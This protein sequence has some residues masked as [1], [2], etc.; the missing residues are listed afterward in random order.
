MNFLYFLGGALFLT[1]NYF[2][3]LLKEK[4]ERLYPEFIHGLHVEK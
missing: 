2:Y 3:E 1:G 4:K